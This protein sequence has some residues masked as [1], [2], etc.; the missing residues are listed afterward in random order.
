MERYE[1]AQL[2]KL[3]TLAQ[4]N[5]TAFAPTTRSRAKKVVNYNEVRIGHRAL[6]SKTHSQH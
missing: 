1:K 4:L 5:P 3:R 2:R 6:A